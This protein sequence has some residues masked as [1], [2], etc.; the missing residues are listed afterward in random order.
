MTDENKEPISVI[1]HRA[2]C[3][4]NHPSVGYV[5]TEAKSFERGTPI[6]EIMDWATGD[7][8]TDPLKKMWNN[9][10]NGLFRVELSIPPKPDDEIK[11]I[12]GKDD[13]ENEIPFKS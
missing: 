4:G 2:S 6:S 5:Q 8:E 13:D 3:S 9:R 7:K 11:S 10:R 12:L 1:C